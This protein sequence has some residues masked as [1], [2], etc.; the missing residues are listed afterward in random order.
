MRVKNMIDLANQI[1]LVMAPAAFFAAII[2]FS[3]IAVAYRVLQPATKAMLF[4]VMLALSGYVLV[5]LA[6]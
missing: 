1:P 2:L 4:S 5:M 6:A 3:V